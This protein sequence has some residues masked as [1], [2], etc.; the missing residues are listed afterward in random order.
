MD[1][2]VYATLIS[3]EIREALDELL[4]DHAP[5]G[6]VSRTL[7]ERRLHCLSERVETAARAYY[8]QGLKTVEE[9]A[10]EIGVDP[11]HLRKIAEHRH[12]RYGVGRRLGDTWVWAA[13]EVDVMLP[14][15]E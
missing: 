8:L 2:H 10:E 9:V 3:K 12:A 1:R 13:D 14:A 11:D 5:A 4:P 6:Q 15:G 7:L